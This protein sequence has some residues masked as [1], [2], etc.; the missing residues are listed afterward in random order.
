MSYGG[1]KCIEF[2]FYHVHCSW[3]S[4]AQRSH[5][6]LSRSSNNCH[7]YRKVQL[8]RT[9]TR[10]QTGV[11]LTGDRRQ[12]EC[13][14]ALQTPVYRVSRL[15]G[16]GGAGPRSKCQPLA[17]PLCPCTHCTRA[18]DSWPH[19][20]QPVL[21]GD[22]ADLLSAPAVIIVITALSFSVVSHSSDTNWLQSYEKMIQDP[23]H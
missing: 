12:R 19:W 21:G 7:S 6:G 17:S 3:L 11:V 14:S 1:F 4:S 22:T 13:W 23:G 10:H 20:R 5:K 18:L 9:R 16:G 8:L 15:C 2:P